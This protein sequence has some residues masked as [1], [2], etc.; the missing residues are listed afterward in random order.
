MPESLTAYFKPVIRVA[1]QYTRNAEIALIGIVN[2]QAYSIL[3]VIPQRTAETLLLA[4]TPMMEP[5][6][7]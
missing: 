4:P 1:G 5:L 6:M 2:T 3:T 7:Q